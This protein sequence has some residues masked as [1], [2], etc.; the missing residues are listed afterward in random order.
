M[1]EE[2]DPGNGNAPEQPPAEER[3]APERS[4]DLR[5]I[6]LPAE[7][8][9]GLDVA[10]KSIVE[11]T[12]QMAPVDDL[13]ARSF[14]YQSEGQEVRV[15]VLVGPAAVFVLGEMN[16]L[17]NVL[18]HDPVGAEPLLEQ[19]KALLGLPEEPPPEERE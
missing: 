14:N 9:I 1:P 10:I 19:L 4:G 6:R 7:P 15:L 13:N 17:M 18:A 12:R 16:M 11:N 3:R 2:R 5:K 8:R